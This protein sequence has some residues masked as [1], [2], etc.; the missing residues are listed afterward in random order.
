MKLE[1]V[2]VV[3]THPAY[4]RYKSTLDEVKKVLKENKIQYNLADRDK[5]KHEQFL[6]RDL[7][8]AVGGEGT[9][10]RAA[11][12]VDAQL[13]FG[14]NADVSSKEG[15]FM[16]SDKN[17]FEPAL[18]KILRSRIK[19]KKFPRL[20]TFINNR[21]IETLALNELFIGPKKA[22]H[23]AKYILELNGK[24]ERQKSSGVLVTT[25][26]GSYAWAKA[27]GIKT[28]HL[29][30]KNFQFVVREPYE[31]KVFKNYRLKNGTLKPG[32]KIKILSEM[33][34]GII[35]AD[36][37][38]IEHSFKNGCKAAVKLSKKSLNVIWRKE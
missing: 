29:D 35:V 20:E 13:M 28:M 5:L 3:Y 16:N 19:I 37:V 2:L 31:G 7:I 26:A 21:K 25:P 30:S 38:G 34:D 17:D 27:C 33:L 8:I 9:F 6:D 32:Q 36:S 22:Y 23:A 10:L 1:K 12:F 14:V 24:K 11:Q 18:K 15:F 4:G